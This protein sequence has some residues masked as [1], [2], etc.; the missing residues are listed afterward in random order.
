MGFHLSTTGAD[1]HCSSVDSGHGLCP[2]RLR[3]A[4]ADATA[5]EAVHVVVSV[6]DQR[7]VLHTRDGRRLGFH[8]HDA[9]RVEARLAPR[10]AMDAA[11]NTRRCVWNR[12]ADILGLPSDP[13]RHAGRGYVSL[14]RDRLAPCGFAHDAGLAAAFD[15]VTAGLRAT[16]PSR[17]RHG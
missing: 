1:A 12:S 9:L 17:P 15:A 3:G 7:V 10:R 16:D 8:T 5:W 14:A 2:A 4:L 6:P 11:A 13:A